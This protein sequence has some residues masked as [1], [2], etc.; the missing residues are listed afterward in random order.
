MTVL[1]SCEA[2]GERIPPQFRMRL[3]AR[4]SDAE[5]PIRPVDRTARYLSRRMAD[6]LRAP[7]ISNEYARELIDVTRSLHH[8]Q[9]FSGTTRNWSAT[10]RKFLIDT[11]YRPY[12]D[13]VRTELRRM[14][15]RLPY[16]I[17][18]SISSFPLRRRTS[19]S[20]DRGSSDRGSEKQ[21]HRADMGLLYDPK[22]DDEVDF[23]LDWI[24]EMYD[25]MDMLRVRRNYPQRGT[26]D[27]IT[28]A[29]RTEFVDRNYLGIELMVNQAWASREVAIRDEVI[30]GICWT[31]DATRQLP[32][33]KAA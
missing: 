4:L 26:R 29:M 10:D 9:L 23:C 2:G 8:R 17:H 1:I 16:V 3:A 12:R 22:A 30:D 21:L 13:R 32:A 6:T 14:L 11:I 28:R 27:S 33:A 25:E 31:L 5:Q 18:L 20:S 7:L 19:D 15:S 24:D